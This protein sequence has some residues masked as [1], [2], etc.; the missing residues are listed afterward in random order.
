M[1]YYYFKPRNARA[2]P[3]GIPVVHT[4]ID[5]LHLLFQ[6]NFHFIFIK[7]SHVQHDLAR[8]E[9]SSILRFLGYLDCFVVDACLTIEVTVLYRTVFIFSCVLILWKAKE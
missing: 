6:H 2:P 7:H 1:L 5:T 8:Y 9:C 4:S 3:K